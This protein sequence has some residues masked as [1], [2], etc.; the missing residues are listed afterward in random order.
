MITWSFLVIPLTSAAWQAAWFK[1]WA[2]LM[3]R[4]CGVRLRAHGVDKLDPARNYVFASNHISLLDSPSLIASVPQRLSFIAKKE[5]FS[6]PFMG[7]YLKRQ[8]HIAVERGDPRTAIRSLTDAARAIDAEKKSILIFPEGTRSMDGQMLEFKDG[9]ALLAIRSGTAIVPVA[10]RGTQAVMPSKALTIT[11][12]DVDLYVGDP[13][14]VT[15]F[16][17]KRRGELTARLQATVT[18]MLASANRA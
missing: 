1:R 11:P 9:A 13:I 10:I 5:L 8:G 12:G 16:D 2:R 6:V 4:I 15:D 7:W 3:L 18:E 14:E 17:L